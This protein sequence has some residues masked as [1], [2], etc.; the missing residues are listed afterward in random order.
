M[1]FEVANEVWLAYRNTY[2]GGICLYMCALGELGAHKWLRI[3]A[4]AR[5][6]KKAC[7][8]C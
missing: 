3:C 8:L 4:H 7:V 1:Q 6:T 2:K 5:R